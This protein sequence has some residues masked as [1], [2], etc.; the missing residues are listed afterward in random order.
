MYQ[1]FN[2]AQGLK[3]MFIAAIGVIICMVCAALGG[4]GTVVSA[5]AGSLASAG[6]LVLFAVVAAIGMIV[7]SII[8]IVGL[9]GAGKDIEGC[10]TA[11]ILTII[12]LVVSVLKNFFKS[13][14]VLGLVF[15]LAGDVISFL[16]TFYVCTS[17]ASVMLSIGAND[18]ASMGEIVWKITLV[19]D[20]ILV[21]MAILVMI[22][23]LTIIAGISTFI[24]LIVSLVA[25]ILYLVFLSKSYHALGA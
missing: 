4:A 15:E 12:N 1:Y 17:V 8:S 6:I 7:F 22:P 14:P 5:G 25:Q 3:K 11:F 13:A 16:T 9:Y 23:G 18:V 19:C 24:V 21:V 20:I 10:R 2:A